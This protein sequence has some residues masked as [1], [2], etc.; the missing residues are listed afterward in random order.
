VKKFGAATAEVIARRFS[1]LGDP[2]RI[3]LLNAMHS[4]GE[5]SVGDLTS[6]VDGSQANVSKHLNLL[7]SERMVVRRRE[8]TKAMYGIADPSLIRICDEV[9]SGV[10]QELQELSSILGEDRSG[11]SS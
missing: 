3:R 1:L 2:T 5:M 9:C 7:L 4:E 11:R 8:G 10:E 6:A